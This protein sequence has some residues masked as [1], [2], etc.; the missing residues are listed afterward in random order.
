LTRFNNRAKFTLPYSNSTPLHVSA[1]KG[2]HDVCQFLVQARAD[3]VAQDHVYVPPLHLLFAIHYSCSA[4]PATEPLCTVLQ[5]KVTWT[6]VNFSSRPVH[7]S[8]Q[9]MTCMRHV[10]YFPSNAPLASHV[11]SQATPLHNAALHGRTSVCAFLVHVSAN[12]SAKTRCSCSH[13]LITF[14]PQ[15]NHCSDGRTPLDWAAYSE[16]QEVVD[17]LGRL[18]VP[19]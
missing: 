18:D 15:T 8:T 12:V 16:E 2:H 3:V 4:V 7:R 1:L 14:H 19:K 17:F 10:A 6:C 13:V 11:I 5:P 9:A